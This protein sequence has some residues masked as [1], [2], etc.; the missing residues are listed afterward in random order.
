MKIND[1]FFEENLNSD[2]P[3][4]IIIDKIMDE[5]SSHFR[6]YLVP[7]ML[8]GTIKGYVE[9]RKLFEETLKTNQ[10]LN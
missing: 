10:K 4:T 6:D 5:M 3:I 9:I 2:A 1:K 7:I 8:I